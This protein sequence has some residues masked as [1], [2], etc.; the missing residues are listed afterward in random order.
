MKEKCTDEHT[1]NI[2]SNNIMNLYANRYV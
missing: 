1:M 2:N